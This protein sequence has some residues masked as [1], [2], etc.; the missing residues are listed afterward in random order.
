MT[1]LSNCPLH[2]RAVIAVTGKDADSFLQGLISN[3]VT[4]VTGEQAIYAAFLTPQGKFLFDFF[5]LKAADGLW[6]DCEAARADDFL[7]RLKMFKLRADVTLTDLRQELAVSAVF[8]AGAATALAL[9]EKAGSARSSDASVVFIDPRDAAMGGRLIQPRGQLPEFGQTVPFTDYEYRR[10]GLRLPDGS[11]DIRVEKDSLLEHGFERLDG[12]D[13]AKGC[14]MGQ[15]VTARMKYRGLVKKQLIALGFGQAAP[16][17]G[18]MLRAGD[19]EIGELRSGS[20]GRALALVRQDRLAIAD[21]HGDELL[22]DGQ[23][24]HILTGD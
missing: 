9:P 16:A 11:R 6:L 21:S 18:T 10:I 7:R 19:L 20:S 15:E 17:P 13:F 4:K 23:K 8:G 1:E 3:D 14:Y 24:A 12:V 22:A 2:D 5:V